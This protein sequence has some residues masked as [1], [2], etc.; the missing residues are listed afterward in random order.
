LGAN[1]YLDGIIVSATFFHP[2][3]IEKMRLFLIDTFGPHVI[4]ST[5]WLLTMGNKIKFWDKK[6][7]VMEPYWEEC[8]E[9][10]LKC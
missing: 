9:H 6:D 7:T 1:D 8:R 10:G 4:E 2:N 3:V 5:M